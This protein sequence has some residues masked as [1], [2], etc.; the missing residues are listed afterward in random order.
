MYSIRTLRIVTRRL[1]V[2]MF[3]A[4]VGCGGG[5]PP[6]TDKVEAVAVLRAVLDAWQSGE[7]PADLKDGKPSITVVDSVWAEGTKLAR[8]EIDDA[9]AQPNG[10]DLGCP[11]MLW[12]GDGKKA[13]VKVRYVIALSPNKVVTRD[14]G[15]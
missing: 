2:V 10:Y 4:T 5:P 7:K 14:F 11:T 15:N 8:F 12:L 6:P 9:A 1:I 13:P 3:L